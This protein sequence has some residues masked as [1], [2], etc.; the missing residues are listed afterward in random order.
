MIPAE[1]IIEVNGNKYSYKFA[2]N[3]DAAV[4]SGYALAVVLLSP[5]IIEQINELNAKGINQIYITGH[6]QGGALAH[7]VRAYLGNLPE[8]KFSSMNLFKTY[9]F[10]NPM[11]GNEEFSVEYNKQFGETNMSYSVINP[12]DFITKLPMHFKRDKY[13]YGNLFYKNW[14][15]LIKYGDVPNLKDKILQVFEPALNGYINSSN[16]LIERLITTSYM[17]IDLPNYVPDINYFHV[18]TIRELEPFTYPK[19]TVDTTNMTKKETTKL[20]R[21]KDSNYSNKEALLSQHKPYNYYV[22]I[23]KE[24]FFEEYHNLEYKYL[25][26]NITII[27]YHKLNS[28]RDKN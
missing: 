9:S 24:Y 10:A 11:C 6:S 12:A 1:G 25:P 18:G 8:G 17:S 15:D 26:S 23:L 19:V 5:I 13:L 28:H 2:N 3:N 16:Y 14:I 21:D 20:K 27:D 7:M 22:A 4:H